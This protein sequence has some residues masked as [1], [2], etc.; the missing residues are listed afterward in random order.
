MAFLG[1]VNLHRDVAP[2][3]VVG[4]IEECGGDPV[5]VGVPE[6]TDVG[7]PEP[8]LAGEMLHFRVQHTAD[9]NPAGVVGKDGLPG[10][11]EASADNV[12]FCFQY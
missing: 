10:E 1:A 12:W 7:V 3:F 5:T 6:V 8:G 2:A 9:V 4:V 11:N